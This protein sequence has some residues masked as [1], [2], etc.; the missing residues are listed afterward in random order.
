M[1]KESFS[2]SLKVIVSIS[3]L[4]ENTAYKCVKLINTIINIFSTTK[5]NKNFQ[6]TLNI[7]ED[8][9]V[10]IYILTS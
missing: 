2:F 1:R 10:Y 8:E 7:A 6:F 9:N 3:L 5:I 4:P